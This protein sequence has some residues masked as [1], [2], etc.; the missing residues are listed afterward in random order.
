VSGLEVNGVLVRDRGRVFRRDRVVAWEWRT[1][2]TGS[3]S[4]S[5]PIEEPQR[6]PE[7]ADRRC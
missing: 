6:V 1:V 5:Q 3:G 4:D 7:D 2:I